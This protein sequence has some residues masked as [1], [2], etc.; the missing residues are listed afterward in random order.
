M[1]KEG[2]SADARLQMSVRKGPS[3]Q[4]EV[5]GHNGLSADLQS[6][7]SVHGGLSSE[8]EATLGCLRS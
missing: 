3:S 6:Q 8:E 7:V 2:E 4:K 5:P 1:G